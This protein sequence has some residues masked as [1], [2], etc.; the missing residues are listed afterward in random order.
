[1]SKTLFNNYEQ[2]DLALAQS[3]ADLPQAELFDLVRRLLFA[4]DYRIN[5]GLV[6]STTPASA[7]CVLEIGD[8]VKGT[9]SFYSLLSNAT[10]N[11]LSGTESQAGNIW[12]TGLAADG[13]DPRKDIICI[14]YLAK[15]GT[16]ATKN[17]IDPTTNPPTQ[18]TQLVDTITER[19]YT[20]AVIHGSPNPS[21]AEPAVP[22]GYLK[23][24]VITVQAGATVINPG[25][26]INTTVNN[27]TRLDLFMATH[28]MDTIATDFLHSSGVFNGY[29]AS[30]LVTEASPQSMAVIISAGRLMSEGYLVDLT[31]DLTKAVDPVSYVDVVDEVVDFS[32]GNTQSLVED[33]TPPHLVR[34]SGVDV[35]DSTGTVH[36]IVTYDADESGQVC[37]KTVTAQIK[38]IDTANVPDSVKVDYR[39]YLPRYDIVEVNWTNS[40]FTIKSG[41]PLHTP[42]VP[43]TDTDNMK[44]A[45]IYVGEGITIIV[46]ANITDRRTFIPNLDNIVPV[47][48]VP[49]GTPNSILLTFT[50]TYPAQGNQI[51]V[52]RN[53]LRLRPTDDYTFSGTTITMVIA[54]STGSNLYVEYMRAF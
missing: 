20:I 12:G 29:L 17:F 19:S 42:A 50:I 27:L 52:Y 28:G 45:D 5:G 4:G 23:L 8:F 53:G 49:V 40:T 10:L 30:M 11:I 37:I 2:L 43:A 24:A 33:T 39:Y 1:M 32:G 9:G 13:S 38:R 41:V 34:G 7:Q 35:T 3:L 15:D 6:I 16:L 44:L 48:E 14:N 36:Y 46:D 22:S 21:P 47:R 54:P 51:D 18:Y 26:I 31:T 25:N